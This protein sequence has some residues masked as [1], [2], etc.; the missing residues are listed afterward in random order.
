MAIALAGAACGDDDPEASGSA[1]ASAPAAASDAEGTAA[2]C[3]GTVT[4]ALG[5]TEITE[6]PEAVVPL[7]GI[8]TADLLML[9]ITPAAVG[10]DDAFQTS[11][12]D[13]LLPDGVD[14]EAIP[15]IGDPYDPNIEA[16]AALEPDLVVSDEFNEP[17][18]ENLSAIAPTVMVTY[19]NNGGWRERFP[20]IADAVCRGN[21]VDEIDGAYQAVI[22]G[23]PDGLDD[24]VVA[25]VRTTPEG[26]FRIDSL[27]TAFP[28]SVAEDAGIPTFQPEGL[29][30]F[31]EGSGFLELSA[32][33][34][35]VLADADLIV[36]GD[37]S[38]Y[39]PELQDSL[40][41][42]EANPL[43]ETLPAVQEGRVTQVP[44]PIYNG[45]NYY[46]A[47]LLLEALAEL[48]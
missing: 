19:I 27:P 33:Q 32:E 14:L 30:G 10:D 38:F 6:P 3:P 46:A 2:E 21:M 22:D 8:Y 45:G 12:Y 37:N 42:L 36:L 1:S 7:G 39:D 47:T 40:S 31:D 16:I 35:G 41:Q 44:G 25:F 28:G 9:G 11:V 23:L 17:F 18:Y 5:E 48:G 26:N 29:S 15:T 34:L 20:D 43:W 24:D 4:H 13:E